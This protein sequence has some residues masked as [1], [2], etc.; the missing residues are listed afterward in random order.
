[1]WESKLGSSVSREG[2]EKVPCEHGINLHVSLKVKTFLWS[3][4]TSGLSK[5]ILLHA[6]KWPNLSLGAFIQ[7]SEFC[8]LLHILTL[9][10][11]LSFSCIL[12]PMSN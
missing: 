9:K 3:W 12:L 8:L 10:K 11:W 1:V 2:R 6:I 5:K 7:I 4:I